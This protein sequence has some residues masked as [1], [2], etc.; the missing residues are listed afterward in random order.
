MA[1]I[2]CAIGATTVQ[3]Q[4]EVDPIFALIRQH[5]S[6]INEIGLTL[7]EEVEIPA[8]CDRAHDTFCAI[9]ACKPTTLESRQE[10][11]RFLADH[12]GGRGDAL[13]TPSAVRALIECA[14]AV[15]DELEAEDAEEQIAETAE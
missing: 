1:P 13:Y 15:L 7:D 14:Q 3:Y 2:C 4:I 11:I 9:V 5:N 10:K 6:E 8:I 12:A